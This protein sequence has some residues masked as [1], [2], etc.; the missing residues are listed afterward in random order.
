MYRKLMKEHWIWR[1]VFKY[2][3]YKEIQKALQEAKALLE[4]KLDDDFRE[5]VKKNT[6]KNLIG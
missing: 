2:R 6:M 4:D 3:E 5:L 1:T